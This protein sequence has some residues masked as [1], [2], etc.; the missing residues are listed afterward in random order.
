MKSI[1]KSC[2]AL[3]V[4]ILGGEV[5]GSD[6]GQATRAAAGDIPAAA[7]QVRPIIVGSPVPDVS[8]DAPDGTSVSLKETVTGKHSVLIFYRGGW[9]P[10]CNAHLGQIQ[11]AES[12]LKEMGY[13]ILAVSPDQPSELEGTSDKNKLGYRLLSDSSAEA[14]RAFG[15]AF[16]VDDDTLE[17]YKG[18]GIDLEA[19]SGAS[20]HIL[21]VPSVFLVGPDGTIQFA[22][23]D[24][25]YRRRLAPSVLLSAAE[26]ASK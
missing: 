24:P 23:A 11:S 15:I 19:A 3:A 10:Y 14:A 7:A 22:H 26:A 1:S 8:L 18:Y 17:K 12:R 6:V 9:C 4:A 21:P 25:D 2:I 20:H 13:Q 16:R 5:S